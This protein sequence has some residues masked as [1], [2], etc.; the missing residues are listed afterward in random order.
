MTSNN[1]R[2]SSKDLK[3]IIKELRKKENITIE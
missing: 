1:N 2:L 3:L